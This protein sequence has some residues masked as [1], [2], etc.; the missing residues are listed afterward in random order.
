MKHRGS[1][2]EYTVERDA[3]LLRA[4][5]EQISSRKIIVVDDVFK[6]L[7]DMP[8]KRFWVSCERASIVLT[9]MFSVQ[10]EEMEE[11]LS[12]MRGEKG[13]MYRELALR[14]KQKMHNEGLPFQ[15]A[16][17][18]VVNE[19]APR[20]YLTPKSAKIIFYKMC[21]RMKKEEQK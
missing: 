1:K 11:L 21:R 2:F 15:I 20:F 6:S 17:S 18:N 3:D 13:E 8:S 19:Q 12:K 7:V 5:R 10:E 16:V 4:W 14:V 9:K